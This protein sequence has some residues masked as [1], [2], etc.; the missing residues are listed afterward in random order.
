MDFF[1]DSIVCKEMLKVIGE[2]K[3]IKIFCEGLILL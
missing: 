2:I 1:E 3:K